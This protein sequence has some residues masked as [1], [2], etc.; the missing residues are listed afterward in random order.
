MVYFVGFSPRNCFLSVLHSLKIS[1]WFKYTSERIVCSISSISEIKTCASK[2]ARIQT[3]FGCS[4]KLSSKSCIV[5]C[6][7]ALY[8]LCMY[9]LKQIH[10]KLNSLQALPMLKIYCHT[11]YSFAFCRWFHDFIKCS[12]SIFLN[13]SLFIYFCRFTVLMVHYCVLNQD[14][15]VE[16]DEVV[17]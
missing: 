9:C 13:V 10:K 1:P 16:K 12:I 4:L 5:C 11:E 17:L 6:M 3:K 8:V 7:M 14:V 15:A 2:A